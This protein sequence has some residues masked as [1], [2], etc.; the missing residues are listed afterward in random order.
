MSRRDEYS[1][2]IQCSGDSITYR[3]AGGDWSI[4]ISD[5]KLIGEYTT[6]N[7]PYIDDY[8]LVFLTAPEGGWYEASFYA[9]GRDGALE[10]LGKKLG[11][12]I[13]AALYSSTDY[14]TRI[15]W[16]PKLK[17]QEMMEVI[18][19]KKQS[20]W[21]KLFDL[22]DRDIILSKAAREAFTE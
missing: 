22:G 14:K 11:A 2:E 15:I 7:G 10:L 19:P 8:F 17:G 18:P 1:G 16:P 20:F 4:R 9:K 3:S 21:R 12:L 13:E 5:I 6:A